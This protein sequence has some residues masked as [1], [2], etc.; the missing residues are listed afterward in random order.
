MKNFINGPMIV[1][2]ITKARY[3]HNNYRECEEQSHIVGKR[4]EHGTRLSHKPYIVESLFY[5][6]NQHQDRSKHE[7]KSNAEEHAF[8]SINK[9]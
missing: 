4:A 5:R 8:L 2:S 7:K 9:V 1:I 3:C 6:T